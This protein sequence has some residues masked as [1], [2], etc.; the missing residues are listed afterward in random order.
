MPNLTA[1][2]K[3]CREKAVEHESRDASRALPPKG[4]T[5]AWIAGEDDWLDGGRTHR[6]AIAFERER[7][8]AV[9]QERAR[10]VDLFGRHV[11]VFAEAIDG[12]VMR[13]GY[14]ASIAAASVAGLL[15]AIVRG[16]RGK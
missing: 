10:V 15:S 1:E 7:A 11:G 5:L 12:V 9:E 2:Q 14:P 8:A 4:M 6:L 3:H 13:C 16:E